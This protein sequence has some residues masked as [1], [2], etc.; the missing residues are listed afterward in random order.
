MVARLPV[1]AVTVLLL[2]Q[3]ADRGVGQVPD[4]NPRVA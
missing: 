3:A 4:T 1:S 2:G